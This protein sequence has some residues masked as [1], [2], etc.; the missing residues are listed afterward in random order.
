M[1]GRDNIYMDVLG[2]A[3]NHPITGIGLTGD[4]TYR[5]GY[6]Y[7]FFIEILSHFGLIIGILIIVAVV[8]AIIKTIFNKN[9]YIANMCLIWLGY[10]FVHLVSNSYL[11]SFRFWIFLGKVLKGLNLKWK[12]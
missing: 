12:L 8:L 3:L 10:G 4:V 2:E 11:T 5:G 1:I 6:V 9:P 7:N